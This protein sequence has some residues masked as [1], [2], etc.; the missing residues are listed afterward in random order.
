MFDEKAPTISHIRPVLT[1]ELPLVTKTKKHSCIS[2]VCKL[3]K[4][5][6]QIIFGHVIG[7]GQCDLAKLPCHVT[8]RCHIVVHIRKVGR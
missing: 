2:V 6:Y 3:Y 8:Q 5:P 7:Q 1:L 4:R